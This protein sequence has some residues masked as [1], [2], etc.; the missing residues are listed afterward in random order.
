[1]GQKNRLLLL[2]HPS[3]FGKDCLI[4][5]RQITA[6]IYIILRPDQSTKIVLLRTT[7]TAKGIL[8][9]SR[10]KTKVAGVQMFPP[11]SEDF[12]IP[13]QRSSSGAK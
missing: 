5:I 6:W 11:F 13:E 8:I 3:V 12:N 2:T 1:M 9:I 10:I 7:S 4:K